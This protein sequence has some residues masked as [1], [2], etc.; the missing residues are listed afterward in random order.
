MN[1]FI[2]IIYKDRLFV[3]GVP[4]QPSLTFVSKARILSKI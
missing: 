4:F 2:D 3:H 1:L